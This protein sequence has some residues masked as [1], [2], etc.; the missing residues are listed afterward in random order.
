MKKAGA[1]LGIPVIPA[2]MAIITKTHQR[3]RGV[4]LLRTV[5]ARLHH[6]V[7]LFIEP[8]ADLARPEDAAS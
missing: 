7:E 8:G 3:P 2:R 4:S 6:C 5:R 1:K